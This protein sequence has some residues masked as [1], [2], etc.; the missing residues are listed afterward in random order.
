M[1]LRSTTRLQHA[2]FYKGATS[3]AEVKTD[4]SKLYKAASRNV[5]VKTHS[6]KLYKAATNYAEV[7]T[8]FPKFE[9]LLHAF[10]K[11]KRTLRSST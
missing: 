7:K 8:D 10:R 9:R 3:F 4:S 5:D 2:F 11:S 1:T 6:T